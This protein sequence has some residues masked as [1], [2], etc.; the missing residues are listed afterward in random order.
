MS[1]QSQIAVCQRCGIGFLVT[2]HYCA[3]VRRWGARVKV[4]QYCPKCFHQK[5][6]LPKQRGTVQRFNLRKRYGFIVDEQGE[7]VFLHQNALLESNEGRPHEGQVALYHVH[8]STKGPEA[9][10]VELVETAAPRSREP[11]ER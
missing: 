2:P 11:K 5:G 8:Y 6:P 9:L 4:P 7:R 1:D 10:N 3:C